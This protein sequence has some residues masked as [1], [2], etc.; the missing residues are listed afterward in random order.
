MTKKTERYVVGPDLDLDVEDF[1]YQ[2]ERLTNERAEQIAQETLAE[3]A[4]PQL[5]PGR[6]V[7]VG[8]RGALAARAVQ[9]AGGVAHAGR[10]S[11][12]GRG[13]QPL[14]AGS[15]RARGLR[16]VASFL[17]RCPSS[18]LRCRSGHAQHVRVHQLICPPRTFLRRQRS[19]GVGLAFE[20]GAETASGWRGR[21]AAVGGVPPP[22]G[23]G[24]AGDQDA[25]RSLTFVAP[26][27]DLWSPGVQCARVDFLIAHVVSRGVGESVRHPIRYGR[28]LVVDTSSTAAHAPGSS[29]AAEIRSRSSAAPSRETPRP[30]RRTWHP[31]P[32]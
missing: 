19:V 15:A 32:K 28:A 18:R 6:E 26:V 12:R 7:L 14:R 29:T 10:T 13:R 31:T 8:W 16:A 23:C 4:P 5:D 2:G 9:G 22:F 24:D 11:G 21:G 25:G 3:A 17:A 1:Q 20:L 27:T 30:R